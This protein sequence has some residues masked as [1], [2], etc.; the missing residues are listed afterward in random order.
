MADRTPLMTGGC[1]CGA[2]R[3]A[4]YAEPKSPSLCHCRMC[5]RAVGG[6][7]IATASV[8]SDFAWT[9]GEPATFASSSKGQRDFCARCGTP[10]AFRTPGSDN[11]DIMFV[12]LD[13]PTKVQPVRQIGME[14]HLPWALD[15][16]TL[17][18]KTTE[19]NAGA[20]FLRDLVN[21][22]DKA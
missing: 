1:Q 14:S 11:V 21:Y 20:A 22:Q 12:T 19:E 9:K 5:Q 16:R 17:P 13:D 10:L 8:G 2:V 7:Y 3:Y 6:P 4:V 15:L 18:A